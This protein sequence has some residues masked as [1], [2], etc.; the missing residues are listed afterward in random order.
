MKKHTKVYK[1]DVSRRDTSILLRSITCLLFFMQTSAF[2]CVFTFL[3]RSYAA[4]Q[5]EK[6]KVKIS[7]A[8][9][10]ASEKSNVFSAAQCAVR[11]SQKSQEFWV[12]SVRSVYPGPW[13]TNANPHKRMHLVSGF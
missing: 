4:A 2:F 1:I 3:L 10:A 12:R 13:S 11:E 9:C 5:F 6:S 7:A 8:Q